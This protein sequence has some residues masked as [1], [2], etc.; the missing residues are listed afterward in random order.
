MLQVGASMGGG[1]GSVKARPSSAAS[2]TPAVH[3]FG[4]GTAGAPEAAY[5][6]GLGLDPNAL[7]YSQNSKPYGKQVGAMGM[8]N[9]MQ[10]LFKIQ[11]A[12]TILGH[13]HISTT[14]LFASPPLL[15]SGL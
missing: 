2:S 10:F 4:V 7:L 8:G 3:R 5:P 6:N 15:W 11:N 1:G 14:T 13:F 12:N 9:G